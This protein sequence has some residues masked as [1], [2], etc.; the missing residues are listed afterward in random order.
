MINIKGTAMYFFG[1]IA[2]GAVTDRIFALRDD[3]SGWDEN[4]DINFTVA[5]AWF[6]MAQFAI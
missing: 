4:F 2:S 3:L 6:A 1:Q 5:Q